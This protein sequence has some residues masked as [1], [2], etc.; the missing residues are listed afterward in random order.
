MP[1]LKFLA[2]ALFS[3]GSIASAQDV[4]LTGHVLK[5][6]L[7]P[8]GTENCPPACPNSALP[9]PG[10]S[11]MVCI[12][13]QGGC[14]TMEVKVERVYRGANPG[15]TRQFKSRIGEWG[16]S[17]PVTEGLIV[18]SEEAGHVSWSPAVERDGKVFVEPK[19]LG[20]FGVPHAAPGEV[21]VEPVALDELLER[22]DTVRRSFL[23]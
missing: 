13:N 23:P 20:S 12:T 19:R 14:Q 15:G 22:S 9:H 7:Q 6:I 8:S 4:I 2:A 5:V 11:Q 16:P 3:A 17:F 1:K 21:D 18:V 10:A